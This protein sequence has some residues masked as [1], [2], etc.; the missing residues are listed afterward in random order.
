MSALYSSVY[1]TVG[2]RISRTRPGEAWETER[3]TEQAMER[4]G[5]HS[6]NLGKA[7]S[8]IV[9]HYACTVVRAKAVKRGECDIVTEAR[10][11]RRNMAIASIYLPRCA[12]LY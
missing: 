11:A 5:R 8:N 6:G 3:W 1:A 12:A 2:C 4:V 7:Y 10:A 9:R